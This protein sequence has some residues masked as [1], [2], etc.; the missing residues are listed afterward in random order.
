MAEL[1]GKVYDLSSVVENPMLDPD[2]KA[3]M[4]RI[5]ELEAEIIALEGE[6]GS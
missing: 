3:I 4:A 2:V 6:F 1:G 5:K